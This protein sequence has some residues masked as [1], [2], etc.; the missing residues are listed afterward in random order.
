MTRNNFALK[1]NNLAASHRRD[2]V[3]YFEH[4]ATG[5]VRQHLGHILTTSCRSAR[6][7]PTTYALKTF[8]T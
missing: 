8:Q 3:V 4:K 6:V 7:V 1:L 2:A 5:E